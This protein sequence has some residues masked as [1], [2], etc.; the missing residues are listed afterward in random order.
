M[1]IS[2]V[3]SRRQKPS[4]WGEEAWQNAINTN[5]KLAT[6]YQAKIAADEALYEEGLKRKDFAAIN[7]RPGTLTTE[8]VGR[9]ELGR[10]AGSSGG[11]SRANVA[12]VAALLLEADGTKNSWLDLLDGEEEP[13]AAVKRVVSEGVDAAEGEAIYQSAA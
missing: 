9:V 13:E 12:T 3:A 10:T 1:N 4:W 7:L 8:P 2:Y 6:Y 11:V 5:K